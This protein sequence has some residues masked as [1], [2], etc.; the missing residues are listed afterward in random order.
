[1]TVVVWRSLKD[2]SPSLLGVKIDGQSVIF[3]ALL[4]SLLAGAP[5]SHRDLRQSATIG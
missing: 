5:E 1:V 3:D 2:F 4:K